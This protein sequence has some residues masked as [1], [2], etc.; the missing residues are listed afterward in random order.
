VGNKNSD[1][2]MKGG[3][4]AG[5]F[6]FRFALIF[7]LLQASW[8]F[9]GDSYRVV[10]RAMAAISLG[11]GDERQELSLEPVKTARGD[12]RVVIVN[13]S[14]MAPDGSGPVRNLDFH[15]R[16][17]G[18]SPACLLSALILAS[19]VPWPRRLRALGLGLI[20][21]HGAILVLLGFCVWLDS[22]ALGLA[23]IPPASEWMFVAAKEALLHNLP[24][25]LPVLMWAFMLYDKNAFAD[26]RSGWPSG[27]EPLSSQKK[28]R[29]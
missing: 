4:P 7:C 20:L 15:S 18:W 9:W 3:M 11:G 29:K 21:Q 13:R 2:T 22:A 5:R 12:T 19:S 17:L 16:S 10:F 27:R 8:V 1:K 28:L 24:L 26:A 23:R 25:S 14:I 6:L